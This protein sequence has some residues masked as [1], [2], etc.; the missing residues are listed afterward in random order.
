MN[1]VPFFVW[2]WKRRIIRLLHLLTF[3]L[4]LHKFIK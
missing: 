3:L 2:I 4:G 1:R